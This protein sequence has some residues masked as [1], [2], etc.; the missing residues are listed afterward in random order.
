MSV[1]S[2]II[3]IGVDEEATQNKIYKQ[4]KHTILLDEYIE[5]LEDENLDDCVIDYIKKYLK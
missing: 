3:G 4:R 1:K 2:K 5:E